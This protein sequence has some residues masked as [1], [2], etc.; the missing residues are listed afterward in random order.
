MWE[1]AR[2]EMAKEVLGSILTNVTL[3]NAHNL[4]G[5]FPLLNRGIRC[6]I[7]RL[8]DAAGCRAQG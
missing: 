7:G 5:W 2:V 8:R 1:Q 6:S 4:R 3:V